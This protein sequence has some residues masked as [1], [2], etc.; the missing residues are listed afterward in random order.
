MVKTIF[1]IVT[2]MNHGSQNDQSAGSTTWVETARRPRSSIAS[3]S[4]TRAPS[5]TTFAAIVRDQLAEGDALRDGQVGQVVE[6]PRSGLGVAYSHGDRGG[7]Q[8][9][10]LLGSGD[11][12]DD[13]E[14]HREPEERLHGDLER[15]AVMPA[16]IA[17]PIVDPSM[18]LAA[19]ARTPMSGTRIAKSRL[20]SACQT[21]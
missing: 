16:T 12:L 20:T 5:R 7:T 11:A 13:R 14:H 17:V 1:T 21:G 6:R 4:H 8:L 15:T 3:C 9:G 18:R 19:S 10:P 2:T